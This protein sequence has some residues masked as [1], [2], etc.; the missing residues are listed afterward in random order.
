MKSLISLLLLLQVVS[1][2]FPQQS[3]LSKSVNF[4][5]EYVASEKFLSLKNQI[6]EINMIDSIFTTA[7]K[8]S[9]ENISEA[10]L[11]L[12]FALVPYREVPIQVPIINATLNFPLVS[13]SDSI[14]TLKNE[15]LP[16]Y[17]FFDSPNDNYGD[18]DKLAH[19]F[20]AAFIAYSSN[21]FDFVNPIGY[22]VEVFE[23]TFKVQSSID[24]RDLITNKL[25]N[26]FGKLLKKNKNI[27][28]S[29]I[30]IL[31]TISNLHYNL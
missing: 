20:G 19:F 16:K 14:F 8:H 24:E 30:I 21:I 1:I 15:N 10:L 9:D 13:A 27:L 12:T 17:I 18:K 7:V 26:T 5:S 11:G 6:G 3:K 28:P 2:T 4:V 23:E 22:F 25:G 31:R 29:Q